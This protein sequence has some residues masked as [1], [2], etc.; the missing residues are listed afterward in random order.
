MAS[1]RGRAVQETVRGVVVVVLC[2]IGFERRFSKKRNG[3]S[4]RYMTIEILHVPDSIEWLVDEAQRGERFDC[5]IT[6]PPYWTLDKYRG[7]G[8]TARMGMG[9]KG[10][11]SDDIDGKFFDTI[12]PDDTLEMMMAFDNLLKRNAHLYVMC[13]DTASDY[14]KAWHHDQKI[15][16]DY[17]K[18]L[19]WDKVDGGMGY[20]WRGAY[21]FILMF[22]KGKRRLNDL[23]KKD[24][25]HYKRV[26]GK[27]SYF[28]GV[29]HYPTEKPYGLIEELLLNSTKEG[30]W[31]LDPFCGSGVVGAACIKHNRNA[32]L[33]DKSARAIDWSQR[34]ILGSQSE[35]AQSHNMPS[36]KSLSDETMQLSAFD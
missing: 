1:R 10:S 25:L 14:I 5:I 16:F 17:C 36:N 7:V 21:E 20:H 4:V 27:S 13:D 30:D 9:R 24:V 15:Y 29:D 6:D 11:G 22:E 19:V 31:V 12:S 8:T 26:Q 32:V 28:K 2:R 33:L 18:R 3:G 35:S 34:R 23:G